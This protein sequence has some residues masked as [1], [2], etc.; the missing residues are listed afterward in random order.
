MGASAAADRVSHATGRRAAGAHVARSALNRLLRDTAGAT[1]IE[2]GLLVA[3]MTLACIVAINTLGQTALTQLF[4]N[5][6]NHL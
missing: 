1:A 4:V 6:A 2:Y 3:L 5:I